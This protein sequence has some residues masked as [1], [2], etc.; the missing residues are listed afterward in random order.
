MQTVSFFFLSVLQVFLS[1]SEVSRRSI[2]SQPESSAQ[3]QRR[4]SCAQALWQAL[5]A[6]R[7][8]GPPEKRAA[9]PGLSSPLHPLTLSKTAQALYR[10]AFIM[11]YNENWQC[12]DCSDILNQTTKIHTTSISESLS[13]TKT[14]TH[15]TLRLE[16]NV[17][18]Q[19]NEYSK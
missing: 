12:D 11:Q 7:R 2:F 5:M 13:R 8:Q 15:G 14:E 19:F 10:S 9:Y 17:Q 6:S 4:S 3:Q 16:I 1:I 18:C